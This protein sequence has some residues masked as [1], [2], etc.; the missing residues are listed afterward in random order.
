MDSLLAEGRRKKQA[1][2]IKL[3]HAGRECRHEVLP[4]GAP[5][6]HGGRTLTP[7]FW[8]CRLYSKRTSDQ[9]ILYFLTYKESNDFIS[10]ESSTPFKTIKISIQISTINIQIPKG[11]TS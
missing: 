6:D 2:M 3:C 11:V 7:C 1:G 9:K 5:G 4:S 8:E 10:P